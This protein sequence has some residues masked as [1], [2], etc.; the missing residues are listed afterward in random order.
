MSREFEERAR[1]LT[2]LVLA[3]PGD[4]DPEIRRAAAA[5]RPIDGAAGVY[6]DKVRRHA[7]RIIDEDIEAL[8]AE[9]YSDPQIHEL[10]EAAAYGAALVRLDAALAALDGRE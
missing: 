5:G 2:K 7:Y 3:G 9:G 1:E 6:A 8:H 10:T 4:L